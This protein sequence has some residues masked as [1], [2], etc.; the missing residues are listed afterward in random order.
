MFVVHTAII[1]NELSCS[2]LEIFNID[3]I[4]FLSRDARLVKNKL[5]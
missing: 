5:V 4:F 2:S 1:K 3:Y